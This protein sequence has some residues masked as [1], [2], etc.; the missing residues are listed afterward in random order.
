MMMAQEENIP[1]IMFNQDPSED[2]GM[3]DEAVMAHM[4][5]GNPRAYAHLQQQMNM[6]PEEEAQMMPEG[7]LAMPPEEELMELEEQPM[8]EGEGM[9]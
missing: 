6:P 2:Q 1:A 3:S 7:F 5:E 4:Q 8:T 9:I